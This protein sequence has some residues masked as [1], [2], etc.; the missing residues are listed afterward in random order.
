MYKAKRLN[1]VVRIPDE[2]VKEYK[3]LGYSIYSE[4]G[5]VVYEPQDDK[6]RIAALEKENEDLKKQIVALSAK[7]KATSGRSAKASKAES[8]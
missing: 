3:E 1:R 2:K 7:G 5:E 6:A 8:N 4:A